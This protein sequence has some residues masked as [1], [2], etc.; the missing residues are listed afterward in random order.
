[1]E[2]ILTQ[3]DATANHIIWTL[4][5]RT[6]PHHDMPWPDIN[7]GLII[8]IGCLNTPKDIDPQNQNER[9][10]RT[11]AT[12]K[13]NT[14]LLQIL[15]SESAHLIWVLRC[16]RII[17][18]ETHSDDEIRARWLRKINERLTCDRIT[19]TKIVRNKTYTNLV[20]NTWKK[21]LQRHHDLPVDWFNDR[22]VLVGS[23]R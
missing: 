12:Q 2:H 4:A 15:I 16:E 21:A 11:I 17:Q 18:E 7:I 22:E 14:R 3:C 8:G 10:P 5:E 20:K 23:G 1:M 9:N 6:W 13:A 19:A